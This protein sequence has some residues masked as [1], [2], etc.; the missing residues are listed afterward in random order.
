MSNT[1]L[2]MARVN[3]VEHCCIASFQKGIPKPMLW[4][5]VDAVH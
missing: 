1:M 3:C 5:R 4:L 2:C